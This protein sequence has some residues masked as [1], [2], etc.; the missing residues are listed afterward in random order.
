MR[1]LELLFEAIYDKPIVIYNVSRLVYHTTNE[2]AAEEIH[3]HG[4]KTGHELDVH[5]KRKAV[6][7]ADNDVNTGLY[8]RNDRDTEPHF[9]QKAVEIPID[10]KG[11]RLLNLSYKKDG[12]LIFKPYR[13]AVIRGELDKI[14]MFAEGKINGTINYLENGRI[15]EVCL[16]KD[17]INRLI[18]GSSLT[19]NIINEKTQKILVNNAMVTIVKNPSIQQVLNMFE[20][21]QKLRGIVIDNDV[22]FWDGVMATHGHVAEMFWPTDKDKNYWEMPGYTESRIILEDGRENSPIIDCDEEV[23]NNPRVISLLKSNEIYIPM[24]GAGEMTYSQY[25]AFN[26][27]KRDW[28]KH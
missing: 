22:Y 12:E 25:L 8:A 3:K 26:S 15:Y 24:P 17:L 11:L 10:L 23:F 5:E 18:V 13:I 7:F 6:Y 19:E 16:P 1:W 2:K 9:G 21:Y 28:W 14:P 4:F 27:G 20:K